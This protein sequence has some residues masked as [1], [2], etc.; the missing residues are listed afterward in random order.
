MKKILSLMAILMMWIM[1]AH[2]PAYAEVINVE[3]IGHYVMGDS[4]SLGEAEERAKIAAERNA[5]EQVE[6]ELDGFSETAEGYL[7]KD[8]I[9]AITAGM[10]KV[11]EVKYDIKPNVDDTMMITATVTAEIDTDSLSEAIKHEKQ[12]RIEE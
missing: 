7:T 12:R 6:M 9:E 11:L 5:L 8:E 2:S 3:G 1:A 4:E 10:L